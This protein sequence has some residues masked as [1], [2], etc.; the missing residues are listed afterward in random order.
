[1]S[2][3]LEAI[4]HVD[5]WLYE[6][7]AQLLYEYAR[8][9]TNGCIVEIGSYRGRS[10]IMLAQGALEAHTHVY[11]IDPHYEA[12]D[13][14]ATYG[15]DDRA[16][17]L[18]NILEAGVGSVVRKLDTDSHHAG[19]GWTEPIGLLWIDGAHDYESVSRD[20]ALWTPH[21]VNGGLLA[22]HDSTLESVQQAQAELSHEWILIASVNSTL[23][24][25][26]RVY[27]VSVLIPYYN[28]PDTLKA[29]IESAI[30]QDGVAVQVCVCDDASAIRAV[31][32][33]EGADYGGDV[34][35]FRHD[36]NRGQA[37]A[38]NSA[39]Q[40]AHGRYFMELDADDRLAPGALAA[41][42][43]ALDSAPAHVGMAYGAVQYEGALQGVHV[44]AAFKRSNFWLA[45]G[46]LYAFMYRRE[47]WD[48][49]C[50][51]AVHATIAD[52]SYSVQDW[53]MFLQCMEY[54][55]YDGLA[56]PNTLVLHYHANT[57]GVGQQL[58]DHN[59]EV[60]AG[61]RARWP[62]LQ[63]VAL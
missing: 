51:Y 27:D 46:A 54:M 1:M 44:P 12:I 19:Q 35:I 49:G 26:R 61:L 22:F 5:G 62:K 18:L 39:G 53:D 30:Q 3:A 15:A 14:I 28:H 31:D 9:V 52:K 25:R 56:L 50:R 34:F 17:F 38:L 20:I 29:A 21:V 7:E 24:Y 45:F 63:V 36:T 8:T 37:A 4:T 23:V 59:A 13:G 48:A 47:A 32:V 57:S 10:T 16:A 33:L 60:V 11:A 41:L 43:K 42:V 40:L 2:D 55:R 58:K 6:P